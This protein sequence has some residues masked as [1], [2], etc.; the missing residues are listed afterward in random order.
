MKTNL[1]K[2]YDS[3]PIDKNYMPLWAIGT[4]KEGFCEAIEKDFHEWDS[5][6]GEKDISDFLQ[7]LKGEGE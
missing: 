7:L 4:I 1:D 6:E 3:I 5:K 2:F